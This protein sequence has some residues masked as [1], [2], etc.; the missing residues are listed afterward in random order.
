MCYKIIII[1]DI[2]H[3]ECVMKVLAMKR[4]CAYYQVNVIEMYITSVQYLF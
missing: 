1:Y 4:K 2:L 3:N